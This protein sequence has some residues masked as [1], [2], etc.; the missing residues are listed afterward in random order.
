MPIWGRR[1]TSFGKGPYI[2]KFQL[3]NL[4]QIGLYKLTEKFS[5]QRSQ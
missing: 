4:F 2:N 1:Y 5:E 3:Q